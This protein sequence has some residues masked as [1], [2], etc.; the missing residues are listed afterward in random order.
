[1]SIFL[2]ALNRLKNPVEKL[3]FFRKEDYRRQAIIANLNAMNVMI[4]TRYSIYDKHTK[5]D[6]NYLA[7][8]YKL[9][10]GDY[11]S[12]MIKDSKKVDLPNTLIS[13]NNRM[14]KEAE[15][16][17]IE[18][19]IILERIKKEMSNHVKHQYGQKLLEKIYPQKD[20][21]MRSF[22][23]VSEGVRAWECLVSIVEDGTIQLNDLP[24]Y[25]IDIEGIVLD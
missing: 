17:Y 20:E 16:F 12:A 18:S 3:E 11:R 4:S 22:D 25:G 23:T 21:Y 19:N 5:S 13:I 2:N 14:I 6:I 1:M 8:K 15:S 9:M 24:E 10:F 7:E